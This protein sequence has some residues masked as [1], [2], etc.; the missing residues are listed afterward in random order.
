MG[1]LACDRHGCENIMCDYC[2]DEYGYLC[3]E[4]LQELK[5]SEGCNIKVFLG[6]PKED[7]P[8]N[9]YWETYVENIFNKRGA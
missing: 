7:Y 2:S 4:C 8:Y 9:P 5:D 6:T 3:G 1:V